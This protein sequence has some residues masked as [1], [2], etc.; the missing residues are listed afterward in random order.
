M[1]SVWKYIVENYAA[2]EQHISVHLWKKQF[3]AFQFMKRMSFQTIN[4]VINLGSL[5][6]WYL[7][8]FF[9]ELQDRKI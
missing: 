5:V 8:A 3:V 1:H 7:N 9:C 6:K 2:F 4:F